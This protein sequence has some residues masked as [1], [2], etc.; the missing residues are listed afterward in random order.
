MAAQAAVKTSI[1]NPAV[2]AA[3]RLMKVIRRPGSEAP[4]PAMVLGIE[5]SYDDTVVAVVEVDR[6]GRT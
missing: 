1:E 6:M 5:T 2:D 3:V 4:R